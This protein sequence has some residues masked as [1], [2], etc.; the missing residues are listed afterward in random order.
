MENQPSGAAGTARETSIPPSLCRS[1]I[2]VNANGQA[3]PATIARVR[4]EPG[5]AMDLF[6]L[7]VMDPDPTIG[8]HFTYSVAYTETPIRGCWTWLRS[9]RRPANP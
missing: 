9:E 3:C 1:V 6:D 2:F 5:H 7:F 8:A 4:K